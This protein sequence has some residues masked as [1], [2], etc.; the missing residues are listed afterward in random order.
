MISL[1][2]DAKYRDIIERVWVCLYERSSIEDYLF[3]ENRTND[4][5]KFLLPTVVP[6]FAG[7]QGRK[8]LL[9]KKEGSHLT[10]AHRDR[11]KF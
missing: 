9:P 7:P 10:V 1:C 11:W 8:E 3:E 2:L 4:V 6:R 5:Q